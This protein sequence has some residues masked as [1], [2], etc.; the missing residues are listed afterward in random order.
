VYHGNVSRESIERI[1]S[2][3]QFTLNADG[4]RMSPQD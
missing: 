4:I 1:N 2:D 3:T